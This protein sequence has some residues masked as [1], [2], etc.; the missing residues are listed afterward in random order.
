MSINRGVDKDVVHIYDGVLLSYKKEQ[1]NAIVATWLDLEIIILSVESQTKTNIMW[2]NLHVESKKAIQVNFLQSRNRFTD[3]K[4]K[5][6][7]YQRGK[8]G[9]RGLGKGFGTGKYTLLYVEWMVNGA[10]L[11]STGN[12]T[13]YSWNHVFIYILIYIST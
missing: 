6:T 2:Y 8:A 3:F 10:L 1:N 4:N 11:Y 12:S 9:E 7:G 13:Q 5:H